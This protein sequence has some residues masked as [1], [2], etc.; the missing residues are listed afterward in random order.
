MEYFRQMDPNSVAELIQ[1]RILFHVSTCV[2]I[3]TFVQQSGSHP[4]L[5]A[6]C[7]ELVAAKIAAEGTEDY[8]TIVVECSKRLF[9]EYLLYKKGIQE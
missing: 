4:W 3:R 9:D 5:N 8:K 1:R 6:K 7:L 2:P